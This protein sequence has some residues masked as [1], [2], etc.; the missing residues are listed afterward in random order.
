MKVTENKFEKFGKKYSKDDVVGCFFRVDAKGVGVGWTV[1]GADLGGE[2]FAV[3]LT[4]AEL[5]SGMFPA[6]AMK[7]AQCTFNFGEKVRRGEQ[8]DASSEY[9][10]WG[11]YP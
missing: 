10:M 7:N 4:E 9:C 11:A 6:C 3:G 8:S 1:N 2:T 5:R